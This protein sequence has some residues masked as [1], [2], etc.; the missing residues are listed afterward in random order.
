MANVYRAYDPS[1]DRTI[2][3]K[4]LKREFCRNPECSA[5]F[6]REAKAAGALSH[7]NIV[8]I[9]DVGEF[10]GFPYIAMELLDGQSLDTVAQNGKMPVA[11]VLDIA[12]QL[13]EAL[14]YA[15]QMDV[16]HRDIKPSNI[17]LGK[18]GRSIK[19]LD[20]GIAR[21]AETDALQAQQLKTQIGQVLGTPR[22]MSPEQALGHE[23]DGRSDLFSVGVVLYELI[24]GKPA[25]TGSSAATL[26]LQIT[27]QDPPP[28][29]GLTPDCPRGLQ[30]IVSKLM[31]KQ[32]AKRFSNGVQL[33]TALQREFNAHTLV[34]SEGR[35]RSLPMHVRAALAASLGMAAVLMLGINWAVDRQMAA[36]ERVAMTA[37]SS[38]ASFV[39]SN[40]ALQAIENAALDPEQQDWIAAQAFINAA[41]DNP[42]V[43]SILIVGADGVVRAA[44]DHTHIGAAYAQSTSSE[45]G[46]GP[47]VGK[48]PAYQFVQP[49]LYGERE[50]GLVEV[51]VRNNELIAASALSR[52]ILFGLGALALLVVIAMSFAAAR[53]VA[54]PLRR[55]RQGMRDAAAGDLDFRLSHRRRDEFGE[56]FDAFNMLVAS[57]Q[58][59]MDRIQGGGAHLEAT[60]V[61]M[62]P[63]ND[64]GPDICAHLGPSP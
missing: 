41:S 64:V 17:M 24:T 26:A 19:I 54:Q 28:I 23:L 18:D 62:A 43:S 53:L 56:V 55:L 37:G 45:T 4:V 20:F 44:T 46:T 3:I 29:D 21:V 2:A 47:L 10:E 13:A 11:T 51:T 30:F 35:K 31:A 52:T 8:T 7:P 16:I 34:L 1:I 58:Q 39:S 36:M 5:R 60:R 59:R 9:Y 49:I 27:Q 38:I 63:A 57:L 22:Y 61:A 14:R 42:N 40:V 32:P 33:A 25:F 12:V 48:S 6:L 15:H 50:V